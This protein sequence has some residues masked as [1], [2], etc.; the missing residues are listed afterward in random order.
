MSYWNHLGQMVKKHRE[1]QGMTQTDL[2]E[3]INSTKQF[4]SNFENGRQK[5]S[6]DKL[7]EISVAL[8]CYLDITMTPKGNE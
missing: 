3:K 8:D 7:V 2:G 1:Q 4:V 5:C 6:I